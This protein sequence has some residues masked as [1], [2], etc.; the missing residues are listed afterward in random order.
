M[1]ASQLDFSNNLLTAPVSTPNTTSIFSQSLAYYEIGTI[2]FDT[3]NAVV[4]SSFF[5]YERN[6][7]SLSFWHPNIIGTATATGT[8]RIPAGVMPSRLL[9][10]N[11][12][13]TFVNFTIQNGTNAVGVFQ[14]FTDGRMAWFK[15]VA[16][17]GF[18]NA[19]TFTLQATTYTVLL[20]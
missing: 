4:I 8:I 15:D 9:S 7:R 19:Q 3:E 1:K 2:T 10:P 11:G 18:V 13:H 6:G 16:L 14:Y 20:V 12:G 17:N 5:K